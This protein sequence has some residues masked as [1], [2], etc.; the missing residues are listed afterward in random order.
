MSKKDRIANTLEL[1]DDRVIHQYRGNA[2]NI[3]IL[4]DKC[5]EDAFLIDCGMPSDAKNLIE[6]LKHFPPLK[7][8]VCTHFHVDHVSG[9]IRLKKILKDAE[10]WFHETSRPFVMGDEPIPFPSYV[11]T[12]EILI[13]CM[14]EAGYFPG[15]GDIFGGRLYGTPFKKGFPLDRLSFFTTEPPVLPDFETI[16]TPGH[17]PDS[18]SFFDPKSGI[19]ICGDVMVVIDGKLKIN[20]FVENRR[21]QENSIRKIKH[22][23]SLKYIFPG[24]GDCVPFTREEFDF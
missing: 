13:P 20:T 3:Y 8:I 2:G 7:Q 1:T 4:I 17:R 6:V 15:P 23:K 16:P 14:K 10:I 24:H 19:L 12:K 9:W 5:R 22:L 21:D 11:D 18:V